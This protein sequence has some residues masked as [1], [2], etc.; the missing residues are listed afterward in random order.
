VVEVTTLREILTFAY[1]LIILIGALV[2]LFY[3]GLSRGWWY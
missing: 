3:V 1:P 2:V